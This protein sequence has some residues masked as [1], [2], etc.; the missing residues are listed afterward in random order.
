MEHQVVVTLGDV[1]EELKEQKDILNTILARLDLMG[2]AADS[3]AE[4]I[5]DHE[6]RV[7]YLERRVWALPSAATLIAVSSLIY[8]I[9][10]G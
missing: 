4:R 2:A 5:A 7:R 1:W 9:L 3:Q 8:Q 10:R 6:K